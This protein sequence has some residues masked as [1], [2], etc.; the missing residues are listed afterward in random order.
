M[1]ID[2]SGE[3][4]PV[5]EDLSHTVNWD[6][7]GADVET[8]SYDLL[9]SF[10][11]GY[12]IIVTL[13]DVTNT[14]G[15]GGAA[16]TLDART[17]GGALVSNVINITAAG[18]FVLT[19]S[20]GTATQLRLSQDGGGAGD[21]GEFT[22]G[23]YKPV[24]KTDG[25]LL[26][27][28][29]NDFLGVSFLNTGLTAK[30][31]ILWNDTL[32][33]VKPPNIDTYITSNPTNDYVL[34]DAAIW[35]YIMLAKSDAI[36]GESEAVYETTLKEI[37]DVL[38]IKMRI[39][40][41][42]DSDGDVR[43]EHEKYFN[44]FSAQLDLTHSDYSQYKPEVDK[45][46]YT[47]DK[48]NIY[49]QVIYSESNE[50]NEDWLNNKIEYDAIKTTSNTIDLT[51]PKIST[52]IKYMDDN[53]TE[54]DSSGYILLQCLSQGV[55][56]PVVDINES[57]ITAG[58]FYP[59]LYLSWAWLIE[60]YYSYFG[61][62]DSATINGTDTLTLD[63][64]KRFKKQSGIKFFYS[65]DITWLRPVTLAAGKGWI[66]KMELDLETGFYILDVGFDP[67]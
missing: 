28:V 21:T 27:N 22:Y 46:L 66:D 45:R 2:E 65:G 6:N 64:R 52:D 51:P 19:I 50:Y 53:K 24:V 14:L 34:E 3:I 67:Y 60:N 10:D 63:G 17:A 40:W 33:S 5:F 43:F 61:E 18:K 37:M 48:S 44:D 55:K 13:K 15:A 1:F 42:I 57:V 39:F 25:Y 49:S 29:I 58:N 7:T 35:N 38:K 41:Y 31:T 26:E 54:A 11:D 4:P 62:A 47:Y 16:P 9:G 32:P 23:I 36:T 8:A 56:T 20:G 59:N 30:S 12:K